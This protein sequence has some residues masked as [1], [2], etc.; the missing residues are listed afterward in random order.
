MVIFHAPRRVPGRYIIHRYCVYS[1]ST[2]HISNSLRACNLRKDSQDKG[3]INTEATE[4]T[5]S[6]TDDS[7]AHTNVAFDPTVT[8][9]EGEKETAGKEN[10]VSSTL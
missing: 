2:R 10:K 4:Y 3:S 7:A 6:G 8:S 9:P 1:Q 5:R